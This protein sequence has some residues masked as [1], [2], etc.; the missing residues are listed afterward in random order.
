MTLVGAV[1]GV[2]ILIGLMVVLFKPRPD[3][4]PAKEPKTAKPA[5]LGS[6]SGDA[7]RIL[8]RRKA[9]AAPTLLMTPATSEGFSKLGG[10]PELPSG[11]NWPLGPEGPL[12][13]LAQVDL[14]A[15]R[16]AGGP[17][18]LPSEGAIYVFYDDRFGMRDQIRIVFSAIEAGPPIKPPANQRRG[19]RRPER[20]VGF[21]LHTSV[22]SLDWLGEDVRKI[23]LSDGDLDGL[24][25]LP[26]V[27]LGDGPHHRLGGYPM[28][29]QEEQLPVYAECEA[30]SLE[31]RANAL[32]PPDIEQAAA[33]W[34]L[35]IQIDS[36]SALKMNWGDGGQFYVLIRE[37][38]A[39]AG[40]FSQ[41]VTL[42]QTY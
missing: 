40:D 15:T 24:S 7:E 17:D 4:P 19:W 26:G 37:Q 13:F 23:D 5:T 9:M 6:K 3:A 29:I 12:G 14:T 33:D 42:S 10:D 22:P 41:T 34:R 38:D 18:W 25:N 36:D 11:V 27:E 8:A 31:Y 32:T 21:S 28:E 35:L 16:H 39:R 30:R 20:R 1:I 2:I